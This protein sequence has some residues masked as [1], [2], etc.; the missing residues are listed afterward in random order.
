MVNTSASNTL[1][2]NPSVG[3]DDATGSQADPYQTLTRALRRATAGVTVQL[4]PGTY[5]AAS[6]EVITLVEGAGVLVVGDPASRGKGTVISGSGDYLSP[7]F[8]R[9]VVALR[10]ETDAE[11][12]GVTVTNTAPRGTGVWIESAAPAIAQCTF[13]NC[14]REGVFAS[15][16]AIPEIVDSTF[17]QNAASGLSMA[18]NAKGEIR[19]NVFQQTGYGIAIGDNAAP[20]LVENQLVNNRSG[21]VV[22]GTSR[23]VLRSN[24]IERSA[25]D[26][27]AV[28][29]NAVPDLGKSQDPGDNVFLTSG[30][31]DVRNVSTAVVVSVG[32]QLNPTRINVGVTTGGKGVELAASAVVEQI[33]TV[34]Q[35][36]PK[37]TPAPPAP[38][39]TQPPA[40][41][42]T[43]LTDLA[44]HW[45]ESFIAELVKRGMISGFP[46][47]TF[48]PD[49]TITR[50]QYAA[51]IAR[52]FDLPLQRQSSSF[53]DV[54]PGFWAAGAIAKAEA[55]GF[56]VGFPDGAFRPDLNLTRVQTLV[57][58]VNGLGLVGGNSGALGVYRDRAQVPTYATMAVATA[59][60]KR[61]VVNH[62]Q[63]DVLE[64]MVDTS[65]AEVAAMIYQALVATGQARAIAS[66]YIVTPNAAAVSFADISGH[67]ASDFI[68]GLASQSLVSGFEDGSFRPDI[69]MSRAQ[70]AALLVNTFNPLPKRAAIR[71][72]DVP[73]DHW[74]ATAVQRVYQGR[75]LSGSGDGTFRPD[76]NI[77]R[78]EVLLS[79]V[80]GLELPAGNLALL[81]RYTDKDSVPAFA[82]PVVASAT[83]NRLV[84]NYPQVSRLQPTREA[85]RAEVTAMVYQA[86]VQSGRSPAIGSP[87]IVDP[88]SST[89]APASSFSTPA[90]AS[91]N[92]SGISPG[93]A[94]VGLSAP[95]G[96]PST[97]A[98]D[99]GLP[100]VVLDPGHGGSDQGAGRIGSVAEKDLVLAIALDTATV[101]RTFNVQVVLTR[102][103]D[104]ALSVAERLAIAQTA[105]ARALISLHLNATRPP[106][107]DVNGLET[108]YYSGTPPRT[109]SGTTSN[110]DSASTDSAAL[111][112][113]VHPTLI[114]TLQLTD[115]GI[116]TATFPILRSPT[117]PAIHLEL[118][119]LTGNQDALNLTNPDY[120]TKLSRAIAV[121]ILQF[122][123]KPVG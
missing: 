60:Q 28:L 4:A 83:A 17:Q 54:A 84:V 11:L 39:P 26:G 88:S 69:S 99:S 74:A 116:K 18:R 46:D 37:P 58:L 95:M 90:S 93:T 72:S 108:Y 56:L 14:G 75:L 23:P 115:R 41:G 120:R 66:P 94:S 47:R 2:V 77:T 33:R 121:G 21:V 76:Q 79:L 78:I 50:A 8:A 59:T 64:P 65:R 13:I 109:T 106:T 55:M 96:N 68:R 73:P 117:V 51:V 89:A 48:R 98:S 19:R 80:N 85:S 40:A 111:A 122:V 101:L 92:P 27:L 7:T 16:T 70:Y 10:L 20:L 22:S 44:G 82:Q 36:A 24:W 43:E 53:V 63:V 45:A 86:L 67:W 100:T 29:G 110:T 32:N 97:P 9:Q 113:L 91:G 1:Y 31:S 62:P 105:N 107:P 114:Q 103:D 30:G 49:L 57:S 42:Q 102:T 123:Q 118:G 12:R 34:V 71:F 104:R 87:Y 119:F 112:Q 5:S 52:A 38:A 61:L 35:P 6:G 25:E 15:G 3:R 81:N